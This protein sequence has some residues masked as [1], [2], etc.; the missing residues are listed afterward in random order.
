MMNIQTI[1]SSGIQNIAKVSDNIVRGETLWAAR[2]R[3]FIPLLRD[4][5]V[6]V[7][8]DLRTA[9]FTDRYVEMCS[10]DGLCCFHF[11]VD[12]CQTDDEEII[13]FLPQLF[14]L[15]DQE[16]CYISCQQ[17]LHRTDIALALYYLFHPSVAEIPNLFGHQKNGIFRCDDIMRRAYRIQGALKKEYLAHM[18]LC[19]DYEPVFLE[20]KK[21][22]LAYNRMQAG[23]VV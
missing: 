21:N 13:G 7:I 14:S 12:S 8:I 19:K 3:K 9:D 16:D 6:T 22:L 15:L 11:P 18:G 17:G 5:G 2:N 20:R 23:E 4:A 10:G 1:M